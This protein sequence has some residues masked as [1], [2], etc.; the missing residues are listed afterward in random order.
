MLVLVLRRSTDLDR[1]APALSDWLVLA[2][3]ACALVMFVGLQPAMA[4]LRE[5]AGPG[6]RARV[7]VL[8]AVRR[9]C[10]ACRSCST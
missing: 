7:A 2:M 5:A 3:L 6:R 9:A 8:D 10:M 4:Q 1:A